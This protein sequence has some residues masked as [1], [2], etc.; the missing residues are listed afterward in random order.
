MNI[1]TS[2]KFQF[3]KIKLIYFHQ[4]TPSS[5]LFHEFPQ[6]KWF[7]AEKP[8]KYLQICKT[9]ASFSNR[10]I[11]KASGRNFLL[12]LFCSQIPNYLFIPLALIFDSITI[13]V[14]TSK[15]IISKFWCNFCLILF[16]YCLAFV[17]FL[18]RA[19]EELYQLPLLLRGEAEPDRANKGED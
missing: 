11:H 8:N 4:K 3:L 10:L 17:C 9:A 18:K 13:R 2:F 14:T 5:A 6:N 7:N 19:S 15:I 12:Q 16:G 1:L